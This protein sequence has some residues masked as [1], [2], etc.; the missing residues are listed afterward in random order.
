[1]GSKAELNAELRKLPQVEAVLS[2]ARL[3]AAAGMFRRDV[4]KRLVH[5]EIA[6]LRHRITRGEL[7]QAPDAS[8]VAAAVVGVAP[9]VE[10]KSKW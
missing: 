2:S 8:L 3:E 9:Q 10:V 4:I 1:M 5:E 7:E 6:A